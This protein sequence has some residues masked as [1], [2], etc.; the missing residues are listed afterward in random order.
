M[1]IYKYFMT[2]YTSE[3]FGIKEERAENP[4]WG[5]KQKEMLGNKSITLWGATGAIP[6]N[7]I[8]KVIELRDFLNEYLKLKTDKEKVREYER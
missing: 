3:N 7:D 5:D 4:N 6:I 2:K 8:K 1:N